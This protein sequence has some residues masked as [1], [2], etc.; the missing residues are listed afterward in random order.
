[1]KAIVA[2]RTAKTYMMTEIDSVKIF[3]FYDQLIGRNK[4]L[5]SEI[6]GPAVSSTSEMPKRASGMAIKAMMV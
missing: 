1:M 3:N 5:L 6:I 2:R 4:N